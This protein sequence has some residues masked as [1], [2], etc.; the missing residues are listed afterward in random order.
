MMHQPEFPK[1]KTFGLSFV[2]AHTDYNGFYTNVFF[3]VCFEISIQLL[4]INGH[5]KLL[6]PHY[7]GGLER[8]VNMIFM[9]APLHPM[10]GNITIL[11]LTCI[12]ITS[13]MDYG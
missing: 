7:L 13:L 2:E 3:C 6:F 12:I 5:L 9:H 8:G 10:N 4:T 1:L 11:M